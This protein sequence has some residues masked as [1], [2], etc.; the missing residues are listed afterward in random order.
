M[1]T[2]EDEKS[3]EALSSELA[4]QTGIA[5]AP[6]L[7]GKHDWQEVPLDSSST[8]C[9]RCHLQF[10]G[11]RRGVSDDGCPGVLRF[12]APPPA[13]PAP[14]SSGSGTDLPDPPSSPSIE[15]GAPAGDPVDPGPAGRAAKLDELRALAGLPVNDEPLCGR[16][17][18]EGARCRLRA[19]HAPEGEV[20]LHAADGRQWVDGQTLWHAT[21]G[22]SAPSNGLSV[23]PLERIAAAFESIAT[24]LSALRQL[25]G[26]VVETIWHTVR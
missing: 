2:K 18:P 24:D 7:D 13:W 23:D 6:L 11:P 20:A 1:T 10:R 12:D 15:E 17:G 26:H 3:I 9:S 22:R 25:A 5:P 16:P 4:D 21:V 8:V 14:E 19:G